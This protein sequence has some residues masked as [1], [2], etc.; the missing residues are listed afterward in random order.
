MPSLTNRSVQCILPVMPAPLTSRAEVLSRLFNAFRTYG[1]EGATLARLS[2]ATGLRR[3]SLYHYFPDGK[4]GMA[5][6]VIEASREWVRANVK[7]PLEQ[8]DSAAPSQ[9][10]KAMRSIAAGYDNGL[11]SCV[12]NVFGIGDAHRIIRNELRDL[13]RLYVAAFEAFLRNQ[14]VASA[15]AR[16]LA[17][18]TVMQIE[19]ALVMARALDDRAVFTKR[20]E[21]IEKQYLSYARKT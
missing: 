1:Y 3:A 13:T 11:S 6:A 7:T 17:L 2:E 15:R 20:L 8:K 14:H 21:Q 10:K 18:D 16:E 4:E 5:R 19:G 12:V 9:L